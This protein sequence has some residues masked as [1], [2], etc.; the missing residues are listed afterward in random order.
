MVNFDNSINKRK[1]YVFPVEQISSLSR[2]SK[3]LRNIVV[4]RFGLRTSILQLLYPMW[5]S[6]TSTSFRAIHCLSL[7]IFLATI[8]FWN[9]FTLQG[10]HQRYAFI[11]CRTV[12]RMIIISFA[13]FLFKRLGMHLKKIIS[14]ATFSLRKIA[15]AQSF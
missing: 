9:C 8:S 3:P 6:S 14:F 10:W 7:I 15:N 12:F 4:F 13:N 11:L 1:W 2:P 5:C